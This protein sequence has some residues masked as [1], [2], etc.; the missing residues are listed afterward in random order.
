MIESIEP[1]IDR[2]SAENVGAMINGVF[3]GIDVSDPGTVGSIINPAV[4]TKW[5]IQP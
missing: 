2:E 1:E 3:T 5:P 4:V